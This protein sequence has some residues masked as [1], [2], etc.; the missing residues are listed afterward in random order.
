MDLTY[1]PATRL[2]REG[3]FEAILTRSTRVLRTLR[4]LEP[5]LRVIVAHTLALTGELDD[6]Y[7]LAEVDRLAQS[8]P[9]IRWRAELVLA[10]VLWRKAEMDG[11]LRHFHAAVRLAH[12]SNSASKIAWANL[13]LFRC[14]IDGHPNSSA[15]GMLPD[16]RRYVTR[17]AD[18]QITAY[19]H[20]CV[21]VLAGQMGQL[22]EARRHC[23]LAE[24]LLEMAPSQWLLGNSLVS[25][26]TLAILDCDLEQAFTCLT[27]AKHVLSTSGRSRAMVVCE[28]SLAHLE[29]LTGQFDRA[30]D[31]LSKLLSDPRSP[32]SASIG[33][34]ETLARAFLAEG[35]LNE[36][37]T[38]LNRIYEATQQAQEQT[39]YHVRWAA[40]TKARLL[41]KRG[42]FRAA[43]DWLDEVE[44]STGDTTDISFTAQLNLLGSCSAARSNRNSTAASRLF[45]AHEA[46]ILTQPELQ[47]Q[48]YYASAQILGTRSPS[49]RDHLRDRALR[50]WS[51][52]GIVSVRMEMDVPA[53]NA[54]AES[55]VTGT[56]LRSPSVSVECV[57]DSLAALGDLAHRPRLLGDEMVSVIRALDCSPDV[58]IAEFIEPSAPPPPSLT[59]AVLPLGSDRH[60]ALA[61][62]C[63][64]PSD[65]EK[66]ILLANVLRLGRG[67]LALER[68]RQVERSRAAVWPASPAEEQAGALFLAEDMQTLLATARRI[69]PTSVPVLITGETGTGKEVL[70]RTIHAYSDRSTAT[71]LPFNCSG[72]PREMLDS[73]LFGHRKG[74]FTGATDH[75]PGVIR[76]AAGGTLFLDEIG[77]TTLEVQPKLLRFLESHEVHPIGELQ[78]LQTDVRVIAATNADL[79]ALVA[80][81]AFRE[82]LFYRLNI[83]RL[84]VPPLRERRMEIP[85]FAEHFLRK[86]AQEYRKD[87]L[88]LAEETMEY[89][90]LYRWPGNVRQLA[91][92]MRRLAALAETG[93]ILMP[94]HLSPDIAASRRTVPASERVLEPT[95]TVVRIDQ[96]V[97]A[98]VQHL[99]RTMMQ[100]ALRHTGGHVE[101]AAEML[102]LSRKGLYL[103]RRRYG[104]TAPAAATDANAS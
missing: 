57:T 19:L 76:A 34:S 38:E 104:L 9:P 55:A 95:E 59:H 65:P 17:A 82:D 83:V 86:H 75:F 49:L 71:F 80:D 101:E 63:R 32:R 100:Y 50:L 30:R 4:S 102:G 10:L 22:D 39:A 21:A 70:A 37:E 69:A 51:A 72:V 103:K 52:Q 54:P 77:D 68:A 15:L 12:E 3:D 61:L 58:T 33:L 8:P 26:S 20:S 66:A 47:A 97:A 56:H 48:Y 23:D 84:H 67:S 99:E 31:H 53:Q 7:K 78:P 92:E 91:N 94:E 45:S 73:Q 14:L 36:C 43:S 29:L 46:G 2:F 90:V 60:K 42:S 1:E 85:A 98:A 25:R 93:A 81:G 62:V 35:R 87:N 89:L 64:V 27:K 41:V 40:I 96:P 28:G 44:R 11:A 88:R 79:D 5:R 16:L 74:S 6:A 13:H 18:P 24:S